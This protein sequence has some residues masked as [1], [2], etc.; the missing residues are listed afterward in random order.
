MF[1]FLQIVWIV[2]GLLFLAAVIIVTYGTITDYKPSRPETLPLKGKSNAQ[3]TDTFSFVTWNMGFTGLG[4]ESDFFLD[5]GENVIMPKMCVNK[6]RKGTWAALAKMQGV[7]F[8]LL[9]EIDEWAKR[10]YY[11]NHLPQVAE[12]LPHHNYAFATNLRVQVPYP[13]FRPLGRIISGIATYCKYQTT[14]NTRFPFPGNFWW[15]KSLY[16]PDRCLLLQRLPLKNG[17]EL[18]VINTHNS[19]YDD[20]SLKHRQMNYMREM[21]LT[22][23]EKGNYVVAGGDWNLTPPGYDNLH[24][25][26]EGMKI[27]PQ[28]PVES[29]FMP[30]G[31]QWVYDLNTPTNRKTCA[32]YQKGKTFTTIIDFF[33][34]SPNIELVEVR[35][36]S[37]N[38]EYSDHQPVYMKVKLKDI[39]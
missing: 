36:V 23:Y 8:I 12:V 39:V 33:V 15:P 37:Q 5:G 9:Q 6:N 24:F 13:I 32:P 28:I 14:E 27:S 34:I 35:G 29:D 26:K 4:S 17:K 7:D 10:S 11:H 16:F 30:Q 1:W 2:L 25:W 22:E 18:V 20:G 31:W 21:F 19:A 38:F 3:A